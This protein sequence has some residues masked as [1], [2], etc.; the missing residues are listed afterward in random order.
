MLAH[1][2]LNSISH[3]TQLQFTTR[4][5]WEFAFL[6]KCQVML[7]L[8]GRGPYYCSNSLT[9]FVSQEYNMLVPTSG[10]FYLLSPLL[11]RLIPFRYFLN[12]GLSWE[13]LWPLNLKSHLS[14][15]PQYMPALF[16]SHLSFTHLTYCILYLLSVDFAI[17][18]PART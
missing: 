2:R 10:P 14:L 17:C 9:F 13:L 4:K 11:G 5:I 3:P 18:L 8:Q 7:L 16:F 15:S 6:T 1:T 12:A